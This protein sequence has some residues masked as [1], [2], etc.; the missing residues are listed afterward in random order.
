MP[1]KGGRANF[2]SLVGAVG[3]NS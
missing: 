2:A 1:P 3:D